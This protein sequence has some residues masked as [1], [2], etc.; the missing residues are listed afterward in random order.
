MANII[1][2]Q[3]LFD[4]IE[5][6]IMPENEEELP[7]VYKLFCKHLSKS[8]I[9]IYQ[10]L[11]KINNISVLNAITSGLDMIYHVFWTLYTFTRNL[12]LTMFLSER[13]LLLFTEFIIMSR[14][15]MLNKDLNFI[16]NIS[17]AV[18]FAFKKT[19]GPLKLKNKG[20][21]KY[22]KHLSIV[23]SASID[24]KFIIKEIIINEINKKI[25]GDSEKL[26]EVFDDITS[27][28]YNPIYNLHKKTCNTRFVW[29]IIL[30]VYSENE[31]E[32]QE[33]VLLTKLYLD[34][35]LE[36][37]N[38]HNEELSYSNLIYNIN[39]FEYNLGN[40]KLQEY[41]LDDIKSLKKKKIY[42]EFKQN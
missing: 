16:P 19:I 22:T 13:A 26:I 10:K 37:L 23:K 15:P 31:I 25:T 20:T 41:T 38:E 4:F 21:K 24:V 14:N 35:Y 34:T 5:N 12:K 2:K 29:D 39:S 27:I 7:K 32:Y 6:E 17:D 18:Q 9:D 8:L 40:H 42:Q 28:V 36:Y 3:D 1:N 33:K 30:H 11:K